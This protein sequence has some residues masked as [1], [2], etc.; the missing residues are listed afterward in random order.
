[1]IWVG[2]DAARHL[3]IDVAPG[4]SVCAGL[5]P[6]NSQKM[7]FQLTTEGSGTTLRVYNPN[8]DVVTFEARAC[9]D[10]VDGV[11]C[12]HSSTCPVGPGTTLLQHWDEDLH[13]VVVSKLTR[14]AVG[15]VSTECP[16]SE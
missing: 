8:A 14:H 5:P 1:M 9:L 3:F 13:R 10:E 4:E 7:V 15:E 12:H 2:N 11:G 16:D 6:A